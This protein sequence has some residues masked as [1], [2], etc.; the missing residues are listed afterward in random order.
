[1]TSSIRL[2]FCFL[3][4]ISKRSKVLYLKMFKVIFVV[5]IDLSMALLFFFIPLMEISWVYV[6]MGDVELTDRTY[7]YSDNILII[8][9]FIV[10]IIGYFFRGIPC[11]FYRRSINNLWC[12]FIALISAILSLRNLVN[13]LDF[14]IFK[15]INFLH[16]LSILLFLV[17]TYGYHKDR[18]LSSRQT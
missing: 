2:H 4:Y 9:G 6:C 10:S 1:M 11:Q 3:D 13:F 17:L 18:E 14:R 16:S 12:G 8:Y 15:L 5:I 7:L